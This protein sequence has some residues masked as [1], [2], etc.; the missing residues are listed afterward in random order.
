M[1]CTQLNE[2]GM[3]VTHMLIYCSIHTVTQTGCDTEPKVHTSFKLNLVMDIHVLGWKSDSST[4]GFHVLYFHFVRRHICDLRR[5]KLPPLQIH[6]TQGV[7]ISIRL[8]TF[9]NYNCTTVE[10]RNFEKATPPYR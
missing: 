4:S 7:T 3:F 10:L 9:L 1:H 2:D 5:S 6:H 8:Y